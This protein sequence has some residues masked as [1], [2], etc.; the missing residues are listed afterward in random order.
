[1]KSKLFLGFF[2]TIIGITLYAQQGISY[3][4]VITNNGNI[5]YNQ[6]VFL[7][8]T[9]LQN[10]TTM[11][12]Q[13]EHINTVTDINGIVIANI[14]EGTSIFGVF[15]AINWSLPQSLKVEVNSGGGFVDMGTTVMRYVPYAKIAAKALDANDHDF[16][17]TGTTH[18]A[19][20]N[21]DDI[22][23]MGKVGI[24]SE[25]YDAQLQ[26]TA[27]N[28][29]LTALS[30][31]NA[32]FSASAKRGL[33]SLVSGTGSG[34]NT[35]NYNEL[36][37]TGTGIQYGTLNWITNSG[38]GL[39]YGSRN[40]L[41]GTGSG[42]HRG[43]YNELFG[44]GTGE[45]I[46]AYQYIYNSNDATHYGVS[47][48]LTGSGSGEHF[49]IKN[50]LSGSG[51]GT[52]Y[53]EYNILTGSGTGSQFGSYQNISVSGG[54]SHYGVSTYL[55]GSGSG[56][57]YGVYSL[58]PS[59]AGGYHMAVYANA[60]KTGSYA[61]YFVGDLYLEGKF[62]SKVGGEADMRAYI[63]GNVNT[64]GAVSNGCSAGFSV[65]K[66]STGTYRITFTTGLSA[67]AY[68]VVGNI[69]DTSSPKILTYSPSDNY[70]DIFTWNISGTLAD[71][72]FNFVVYKK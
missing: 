48:E 54:G 49:G 1:M 7:R 64:N 18:K 23:H 46:G 43:T 52:N 27:A 35:G 2:L 25:T 26:V 24:G 65:A 21:A 33:Q 67:S 15:A 29:T 51:G 53:G 66:Q 28:N 9:I 41:L 72:F 16:Y 42:I 71:S 70:F 60:T 62:K 22:Y 8:F 6:Y 39:H 57:K 17:K 68:V 31:F 58:I 56:N 3:K 12:Y 19:T 4:A 59:T 10:G 61:G 44:T 38:N 13:E 34:A 45:Q 37:G 50:A 14:G 63:Y 47:N 20:I 55:N 11:V 36:Y 30:A 40:S 32:T 5:L 69:L